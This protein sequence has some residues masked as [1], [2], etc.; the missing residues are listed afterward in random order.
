M[1]P[2]PSGDGHKQYFSDLY[3]PSYTQTLS[4]LIGSRISDIQTFEKPSILLVTQPDQSFNSALLESQAIQQLDTKVTT[5]MSDKATPSNVVES[6]RDHRFSHFVCHGKLEDGKPFDASFELHDGMRLTLLDLMRS[7]FRSAEFAFLSACHTAEMTEGSFV[8]EAL[9]LTA[10]MQYCGFRSVVGTMWGMA[11]VDG[12]ELVEHFY[13]SM[14]SGKKGSDL[15]YYERSAEALR[16]AVQM[17]RRK[18]QGL[19]LEQ[20]VKFVHYGA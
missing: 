9:H 3:I 8:D 15:P 2:I 13:E 5:L 14:F 10:A 19:P 7:Q 12:P 6:L 18:N 1:G 16:D 11:D 17:L 4:V 20:W